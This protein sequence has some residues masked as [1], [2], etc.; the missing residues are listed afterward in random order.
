MANPQ[1]SQLLDRLQSETGMH[2]FPVLIHPDELENAL[3]HINS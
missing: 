3:S 1:D 2:I